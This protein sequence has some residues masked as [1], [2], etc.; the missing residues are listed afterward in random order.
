MLEGEEIE[1]VE[2]F[3]YLGAKVINKG[4]A[5]EDIKRIGKAW[6]AFNKLSKIWNSGELQ[7]KTKIKIFKTNVLAVL[8]YGSETWKMTQ[9]D[10]KKLDT[11]LHKA[12][13]CLLKIRW[14]CVCPMRR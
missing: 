6:A 13:R 12:P 10:E 7:R 1:E 2:S 4:G 14:Q 5:D 11:F 9:G 3:E 8:M